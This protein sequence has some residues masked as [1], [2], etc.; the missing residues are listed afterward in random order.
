MSPN[1]SSYWLDAWASMHL[2]QRQF[3][4]D[5]PSSDNTQTCLKECEISEALPASPWWEALRWVQDTESHWRWPSWIPMPGWPS[6]GTS[7]QRRPWKGSLLYRDLRAVPLNALASPGTVAKSR[8]WWDPGW[9]GIFGS[10]HTWTCQVCA[11]DVA[12]AMK[13]KSQVTSSYY[14]FNAPCLFLFHKYGASTL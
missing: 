3:T 7:L 12:P 5:H 4:Q 13:Q 8:E 14:S 11:D 10:I 2:Q 6:P 9:N 1:H